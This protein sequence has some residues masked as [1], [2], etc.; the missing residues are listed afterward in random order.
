MQNTYVNITVINGIE[1]LCIFIKTYI[2]C[3]KPIGYTI[4]TKSNFNIFT[5]KA[6]ILSTLNEYFCNSII[7]D[8]IIR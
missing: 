4:I 3:Y 8:L 2:V 7:F 5:N 1:F 6:S